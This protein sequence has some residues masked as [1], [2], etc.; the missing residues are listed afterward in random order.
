MLVSVNPGL[1]IWTIITFLVL[2]F[3]LSKFGWKPIVGALE[4]REQAIRQAI[5]EAHQ[6]RDEAQKILEA[7]NKLIASAEAEA[8]EIV[9]AARETSEQIRREADVTARTESQRLL[10]Q[11]RREIENARNWPCATYET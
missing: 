2:V 11:A 3:L 4:N 10:D 7:Q 5:A 6:A 1:I 8:R 9:Q